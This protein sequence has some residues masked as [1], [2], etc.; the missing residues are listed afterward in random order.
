MDR[1]APA[2]DDCLSQPNTRLTKYDAFGDLIQDEDDSKY[3]KVGP[4]AI[5]LGAPVRTMAVGLLRVR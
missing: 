2:S 1:F 3:R 5:A 4:W